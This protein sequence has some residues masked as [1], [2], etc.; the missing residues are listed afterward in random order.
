MERNTPNSEGT[1]KSGTRLKRTDL[2]QAQHSIPPTPIARKSADSGRDTTRVHVHDCR[3]IR[4]GLDLNNGRD[5]LR[6]PE[7][8]GFGKNRTCKPYIS[9]L[10]LSMTP[11]SLN[12]IELAVKFRTIHCQVGKISDA[13]NHFLNRR[14][15]CVK[16]GLD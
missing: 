7:V 13:C 8:G 12:V 16:I 1:I 6:I 11:E 5:F 10:L 2:Y 14:F 15:L 9:G 3:Y 4:S